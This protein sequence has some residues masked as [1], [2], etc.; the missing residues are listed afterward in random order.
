ML[1]RVFE[2]FTQI[3]RTRPLAQGGLGI[4]LTIVKRLVEMH[5]GTI[6]AYSAGESQGSQFTVTAAILRESTSPVQHLTPTTNCRDCSRRILVVDDNRD[7]AS[8]Y[9]CCSSYR[10]SNSNGL[11]RSRSTGH[12]EE[13]RPAVILLDIGMPVMNGYDACRALRAK[14]WGKS[15]Q[16]IALTGWGQDEDRRKTRTPDSTGT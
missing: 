11:R 15:V 8:R 1:P 6:T 14:D 16:I 13:F 7:S 9:R 3:E 12:R 5:Q 2:M 10:Q 4:G